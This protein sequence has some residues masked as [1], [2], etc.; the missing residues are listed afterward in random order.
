MATTSSIECPFP[1]FISGNYHR[2][3]SGKT[4]SGTILI[5]PTYQ[6]PF[7]AI[8]GYFIVPLFSNFYL[9]FSHPF[10][11]LT[12]ISLRSSKYDSVDF[13]VT[14]FRLE[15]KAIDESQITTILEY[16]TRERDLRKKRRGGKKHCVVL[17]LFHFVSF[18]FVD[19]VRWPEAFQKPRDCAVARNAL[20]VPME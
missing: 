18:R 2:L 19:N 16:S 8:R 13:Y 15:S 17:F 3:P 4:V 7:R 6:E 5:V 12:N 14:I 1:S 9:Y 11:S 10:P 20:Y